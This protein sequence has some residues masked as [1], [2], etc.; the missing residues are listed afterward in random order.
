MPQLF[1]EKSYRECINGMHCNS[2]S[3]IFTIILN[4]FTQT[5]VTS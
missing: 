3:A 2:H 5:D 4:N 1:D